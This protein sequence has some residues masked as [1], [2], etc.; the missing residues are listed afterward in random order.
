VHRDWPGG[1]AASRTWDQDVH[2]REHDLFAMQLSET[3]GIHGRADRYLLHDDDGTT[4]ALKNMPAR[5]N[6]TSA[7][8]RTPGAAS[9]LKVAPVSR[10]SVGPA[11]LGTAVDQPV[12]QIGRV[13]VSGLQPG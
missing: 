3:G 8:A 2:V 10:P 7:W 5:W 1:R 6:G 4:P 12:V 11:V 9:L 13:T